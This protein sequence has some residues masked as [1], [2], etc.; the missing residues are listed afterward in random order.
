MG[1]VK[2]RC[3]NGDYYWVSAYV[4]PVTESGKVVG[5]ESVRSCPRKEDVERA[6]KLYK[7]IN[8][9]KGI[10]QW[11]EKIPVATIL[12]LAM[13]AVAGTLHILSL[14]VLAIGL[15][16]LSLL[17]SVV[18]K[19]TAEKAL[20]NSI[21]KLLEKSF[22]DTLAA[23]SYTDDSPDQGRIK[24]AVM[25][26]RA[27]LD[28]ILTRLEDSAGQVTARSV[29]G[30]AIAHE[31]QEALHKQQAETEQVATAVHEMSTTIAEVSANVQMTATKAENSREL[32]TS[33]R[34]VV[35]STRKAIE[36][37]KT[38]VDGIRQSVTDLAKQSHSIA[39]AAAIIEQIADQTNLLALNAA[40]E[41]ARA[42]EHGR[43]FAV[44]ADEVRNLARRTQD[45]TQE[46]H[47]VLQT[48]LEGS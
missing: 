12:L 46:I 20:R 6:A 9:G 11:W 26:Q 8:D 44:V 16:S 19:E 40:I 15:L 29:S 24:V 23:K 33:G 36:E 41:A 4:T 35:G 17:A 10:V 27:H 14:P 2:N 3:K 31:T 32:A 5:Y 7:R 47:S 39:S 25:A 43:G 34:S 38:T 21:T 37:L 45:S 42:G 22:T 48:L 13:I 30:L 1:L 18:W 28:A